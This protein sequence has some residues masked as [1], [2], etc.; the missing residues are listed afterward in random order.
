M[1]FAVALRMLPVRVLPAL[2]FRAWLTP[3]PSSPA[4]LTGDL[5]AVA[6]LSRNYFGGVP[7]FEVG[8]GPVALAL[9]GWGG[10][11]A[12]MAPIARRLADEG[13]RVVIPTLPGHAGGERTDIKKVVDALHALIDDV[14]APDVIVAHSFAAMALR[15]AFP[16]RAPHRV[17]LVA[18]ALDVD[19]ALAVFG[20]RLGLFPWA[21]R[22]L[23]ARLESW[24]P[25]LWPTLSHV[26]PDQMPGADILI[27]HDPDDPDTPFVRSAEL[28]AIRPDT[29]I[30]AVGSV[31]HGAILSDHS[32][33][34]RLVEFVTAHS[35]SRDDAA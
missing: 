21:R 6:G 8:T 31:G 1:R 35:F 4:R 12:Q 32:T 28:A 17:G 20:D 13:Y 23:R 30:V 9:H 34:D 7:G 2:S 26:D 14:G 19:D 15:L 22:G 25:S 27:V 24:D 10:R 3:P 16:E 18:P 5:E 29:S 33:L 11:P